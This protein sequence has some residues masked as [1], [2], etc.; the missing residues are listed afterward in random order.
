MRE[1]FHTFVQSNESAEVRQ[2]DNFDLDILTD[3]I[4]L[5]RAI[6]RIRLKLFQS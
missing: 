6:P 4:P 2:F 3:A 1:T 5:A